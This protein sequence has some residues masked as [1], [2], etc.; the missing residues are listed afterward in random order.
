MQEIPETLIS[1]LEC[2]AHQR[3]AAVHP[4]IRPP[5]HREWSC[6]TARTLAESWSVGRRTIIPDVVG[7]GTHDVG[8][9]VKTTWRVIRTRDSVL[10]TPTRRAVSRGSAQP[11]NRHDHRVVTVLREQLG[12]A[13]MS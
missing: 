10:Q 4:A 8:K 7:A 9:E 3:S 12:A 11:L 13:R 6:R 1:I 2:A 5:I